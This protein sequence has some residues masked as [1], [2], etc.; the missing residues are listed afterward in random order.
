MFFFYSI[1]IFIV[2]S[3][4]MVSMM[5]LKADMP[6]LSICCITVMFLFTVIMISVYQRQRHIFGEKLG[7]SMMY[8]APM[9]KHMDGHSLWRNKVDREGNS[10]MK[11]VNSD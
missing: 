8:E 4:L 3:G 6:K 10:L 9:R 1:P 7:G 5:V 11:Y 2:S